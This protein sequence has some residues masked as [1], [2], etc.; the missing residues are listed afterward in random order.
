MHHTIHKNELQWTRNLNIRSKTS[1]VQQ[2]TQEKLFMTL[3]WAKI[4]QDTK[5]THIKENN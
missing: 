5:N 4:S 1:N 2:K 3:E